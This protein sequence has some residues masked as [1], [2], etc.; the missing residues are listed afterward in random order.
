MPER[1]DIFV[2]TM[3]AGAGIGCIAL[4]YAVGLGYGRRVFVSVKL[5]IEMTAAGA[6]AVV[7]AMTERLYR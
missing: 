3:P 5:G 6:Y 1:V 7:V 2:I 4:I